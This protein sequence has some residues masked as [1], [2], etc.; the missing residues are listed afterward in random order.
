MKIVKFEADWCGPCKQQRE[1][2]EDFDQVPIETIDVD[3]SPEKANEYGVRGVPA[4][5]LSDDG[6]VLKHWTGITQ[7]H[8]IENEIV[9]YESDQ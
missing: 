8:E 3:E 6:T 4:I 2:L 7:I 1:I 5:V 9:K